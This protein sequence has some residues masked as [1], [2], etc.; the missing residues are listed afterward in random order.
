MA[1]ARVFDGAVRSCVP[2]SFL[3]TWVLLMVLFPNSK[4]W[5]LRLQAQSRRNSKSSWQRDLR[6]SSQ[7]SPC[8]QSVATIT[9]KI[10][11][12]EI[13]VGGLAARVA[14]LEAGA[15]SASSVSGSAGSWPL[16]GR[17]D[18][19]TATGSRDPSASDENRNTRRRLGRDSDPDDEHA[20]SAVLLRFP[21]EQCHSGMSAWLKKTFDPSDQPERVHCKIILVR[22]SKSQE[23]WEI[24]RRFAPPWATVEE[25]LRT[26]FPEQQ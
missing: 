11:S 15:I 12:M 8:S 24:R 17:T 14:A 5:A 22:Q 2:D 21:C 19:S 13:V 6:S 3:R 18:G 16:P 25:K 7:R 9:T 23:W 1:N 4:E 20:R 26:I 10:A